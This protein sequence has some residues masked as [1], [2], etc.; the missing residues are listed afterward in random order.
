M[1]LIPL[2][3]AAVI[4]S[5]CATTPKEP[6]PV[7]VKA[8]G[9]P[10]EA[11]ATRTTKLSVKVKA[12]DQ[13]TRTLTVIARDGETQTIKVPPE[14]KRFGE[15]VAGDSVVVEVNQGLL[16]EYLPPG[17]AGVETAAAAVGAVS[18]QGATPG[19]AVA[20]GV[21]GTV[22]IVE[23]DAQS[24]VVT[25]Q[26]LDGNRYKVKAGPGLAI[27]KLKVGD[28]LVATYVQTLAIGIEKAPALQ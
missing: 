5:A 7:E 13:A 6:P 20:G 17:Q 10:G 28:R 1:R 18:G 3:A 8:T 14:V 4:L 21:Q 23:L 27:E 15:I 22:T 9:M 24:R 25:F 11:I 26:D 12:V 19:A 16:L 2:A